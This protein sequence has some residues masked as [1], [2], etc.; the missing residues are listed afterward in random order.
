MA[1]LI[2]SVIHE[3]QEYMAV[4]RKHSAEAKLIAESQAEEQIRHLKEQNA[5]LVRLLQQEKS[6]SERMKND[7]V[8]RVSSLFNEFV[9]ERDKSL[10]GA[11]ARIKEENSQMESNLNDVTEQYSRKADDILMRNQELGASLEKKGEQCKRLRD[12]AFKVIL[13]YVF[14]CTLFKG[15]AVCQ[16]CQR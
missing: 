11:V 14:F 13:A 6:K 8:Q 7:L 12:G 3:T 15:H 2:Q 4:E 5:Q 9:A 16:Q 10:E 1:V